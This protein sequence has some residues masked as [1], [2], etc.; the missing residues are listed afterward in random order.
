MTAGAE[1]DDGVF[2]APRW[3]RRHVSTYWWLERYIDFDETQEP[4][5][6]EAV[7][8]WFRWHRS[9]QLPEYA[10]LPL[11]RLA[12]GGTEHAVLRLGDELAIRMPMKPALPEA[13]APA[14]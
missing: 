7:A 13:T 4:R 6:R 14:R 11:H 8:E 12:S 1:Q 10:G 5:A 2:A 9:T 3:L